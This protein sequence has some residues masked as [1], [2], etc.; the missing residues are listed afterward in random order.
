MISPLYSVAGFPL[1]SSSIYDS[2]LLVLDDEI[3]GDSLWSFFVSSGSSIFLEPGIFFLGS[4]KK[5][6]LSCKIALETCKMDGL[7]P[8]SGK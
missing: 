1:P 8:V 5:S 3:S 7:V 6:S 2:P 4:R